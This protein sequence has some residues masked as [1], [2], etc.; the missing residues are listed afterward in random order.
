VG[1]AKPVEAGRSMA[2]DPHYRE[3][4]PLEG[5]ASAAAMMPLP[6][7]LARAAGTAALLVGLVGVVV[8]IGWAA[9]L[10][11]LT[12]V[13]P[14]YPAMKPNTAVCFA[15]SA[16]VLALE[17]RRVNLPH[18][19][20]LPLAITAGSAL[21]VAVGAI[22][23]I[24]YA[25]QA[26]LGIDLLLFA[27]AADPAEPFPGRMSP[28]SAAGFVLFG[29]LTLLPRQASPRSG[30]TFTT[31]AAIGLSLSYLAI[32]G[33][34]YHVPLLYAREAYASIALNSAVTIFV[35]FLGASAT[36]PNLG[37]VALL[38]SDGPG[39]AMARRL[40]PTIVVGLPAIGWL[41]VQGERYG[42][43]DNWTGV[44][45]LTIASV[46]I[47]TAMV[48]AIGLYANR[49]D[50]ERRATTRSLATSEEQL[51]ISEERYRRLFDLMQEAVW[52]HQEGTILFANPA[53]AKLLG[54]ESPEV[55][56]GRSV[57]SIIHP[58]DR[59]RAMERT[60]L[61]LK[62]GRRL[63]ITDLRYIGLDGVTRVGASHAIPIVEEGKAR[64]MATARDVTA[65]RQAEEQLR[66]SQK[67]E[68]V[69]HLTGGMAHDFNNLL[70]VILGNLDIA[71]ARTEGD[72]RRMIRNALQAA[73]L[74]A[75]LIQRLLAFSRRQALAPQ[76]LDANA[77]VSGLEDL[78][79][80]TLGEHIEIDLRL[81]AELWPM[82]ADKGQVES[83]LLNLA[84]NAR[85]AMPRGGKLTIETLNA[86]LDEAY[87]ARNSDVRPGDYVM[88]AVTD[89]GSGMT[90]EV[91]E[92]AMEPFFTTKEVG[93]G[94]GLGL[95]MI[96]GF[97]KQSQGHMKIYSEAG[98]GTTVRLYLP[99]PATDMPAAATVK[100]AILDL[101]PRGETILTVEDDA[102]V[103]N[104]AISQLTGLGYKVIEAANGPQALKIL[105]SDQKIDLL[106]TDVVMPGGM[107]GKTLAGLAKAKRPG[108]KVLF[109][110]GYTENTIVH[111]GRLDAGVH[112][113]AKPY[114]LES[115]ARKIREALADEADR[116]PLNF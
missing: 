41:R 86:H 61:A 83:A 58:E 27:D 65:Q 42:L 89:T 74:G 79:R 88:L 97:A 40:L 25:T 102:G 48:W 21:L 10:P 26:D 75:T 64:S 62:E 93:K 68:S 18:A 22:T 53:A 44:V 80:R 2:P 52:V 84:V 78:L 11:I 101:A 87:A 60:R 70:T 90:P 77:L 6:A 103:R 72:T 15:L 63:P 16:L 45:L 20:L 82:L 49:L 35:M 69:G 36:R 34:A 108:L 55:L 1:D 39:G 17:V 116:P 38:R 94:S 92:R 113:L 57:F 47:L 67:M 112:F 43:F 33:Y 99:R 59:E 23:L 107:T 8:L 110:S 13:L 12:S 9:D 104:L 24:E 32:I 54:A 37:W 109:T 114:K 100:P 106:F 3:P 85:D 51:R 56:I 91:L 4:V 111:H 81:N 105:D 7:N 28:I 115:L 76:P 71:S 50:E 14:G 98:H 73:E 95:S 66:H 5:S 46:A 19:P 30:A 31:L 29:I 96:Y